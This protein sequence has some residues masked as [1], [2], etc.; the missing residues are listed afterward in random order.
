MGHADA[1]AAELADED[2]SDLEGW[3]GLRA[4]CHDG[5]PNASP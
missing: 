2:V 3:T 4:V 1:P 5:E